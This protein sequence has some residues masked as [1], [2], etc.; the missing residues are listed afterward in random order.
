MASNPQ[1][2]ALAAAKE[3]TGLSYS[4]I[5]Q[6]VK[7]SEQRIID[8]QFDILTTYHIYPGDLLI[9]DSVCTG[10]AVPT[11]AEFQA[12]AVALGIQDRAPKDG[13]HKTA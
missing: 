11:E 3:K 10:A 1:C 9:C 6:K 2:T 5:A 4:E 8:G 7:T 13:A 12:I